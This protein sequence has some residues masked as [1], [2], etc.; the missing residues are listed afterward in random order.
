MFDRRISKKKAIKKIISVS[1]MHGR[2]EFLRVA[3]AIN[4]KIIYGR[5]I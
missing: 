2:K 5:A 4:I 3:I 1:G